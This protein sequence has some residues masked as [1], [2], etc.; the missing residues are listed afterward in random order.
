MT[1]KRKD[2]LIVIGRLAIFALVCLAIGG[3]GPSESTKIEGLKA[4]VLERFNDPES[5][6]F[7]KLKLLKDNKGLCGE[8][9]TKNKMGGY[10]GFAAFAIDQNGRVFILQETT[11]DAVLENDEQMQQRALAMM[12]AGNR[13]R[14]EVLVIDSINKKEF[15]HWSEC[16]N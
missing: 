3:C 6:Q 1:F 12:M 4:K 13:G 14:A 10:G 15:P 2:K 7:R 9:N 5:A 16:A 8:V 11:L